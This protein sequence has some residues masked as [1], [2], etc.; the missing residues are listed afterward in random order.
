MKISLFTKLL[1][2]FFIFDL[3]TL[4]LILLFYSTE[5]SIIKHVGPIPL[6]NVIFLNK[7]KIFSRLTWFSMIC[8]LIIFIIFS[9]AVS[10][11]I[12]KNS[13]DFFIIYMGVPIIQF[14]VI[15]FIGFIIG[16]VNR[17][18]TIT[19]VFIIFNGF[20]GYRF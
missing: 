9:I 13:E 14:L 2:I 19:F 12:D 20:L 16:I 5:I 3:V 10:K 1:S 11:N 8:S 7:N 4:V 17:I 18:I 6:T 15:L